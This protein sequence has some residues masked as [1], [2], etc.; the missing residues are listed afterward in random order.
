MYKIILILNICIFIQIHCEN[1][2]LTFELPDSERMCFQEV[3][4]K[5]IKCVLEYQVIEG[6]NYDVDITL[7]GPSGGIL[8]SD[9]RKQYDRFEWTTEEEGEYSFCFSNEFSTFTHKMIYFD[10]Q[11]GEDEILRVDKTVPMQAMTQI[12]TSVLRIHQSLRS[13]IDYQTHH[14]LRESIGRS[15]AEDMNERVNFYSILQTI[16][17]CCAGIG[18]LF[19]LRSFFMDKH[20][21]TATT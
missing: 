8:Y 15:F 6:G 21:T 14:R 9:P 19:V 3:L 12:E 1:Y 20:T 7:R 4:Q 10:F 11:F 5:Q 17:I 2:E 18:Q 16:I 13:T